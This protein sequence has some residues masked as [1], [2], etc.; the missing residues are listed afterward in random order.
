MNKDI[1]TLIFSR[2]L[3]ERTCF[4]CSKFFL[5]KDYEAD[6]WDLEI[7]T[8][9]NMDFSSFTT[10]TSKGAVSVEIMLYHKDCPEQENKHPPRSDYTIR[11]YEE[12][13]N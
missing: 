5:L 12:E 8:N 11:D 3:T 2:D 7:R 4:E 1:K 6:N 13:I 9:K 10:G